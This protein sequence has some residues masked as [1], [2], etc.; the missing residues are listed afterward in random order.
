MNPPSK[1]H[2]SAPD[3]ASIPV[4]NPFGWPQADSICLALAW[5]PCGFEAASY[6]SKL[7]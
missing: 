2:P 4:L 7:V 5:S 1:R 6:R 3:D